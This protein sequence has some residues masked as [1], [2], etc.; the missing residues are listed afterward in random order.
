VA[1]PRVRLADTVSD[2]IAASI[3]S[4]Q[5]PPGARLPSERDL[6][7]RHQVSRAAIREA[8]AALASRGLVRTR[9]GYRP[10]VETLN[11]QTAID[12]VGRLVAH[13]LDAPAGVLNLFDTRIFLE[14]ALARHAARHA[15]PAD[16]AALREALAANRDAVGDERFYRTDVAFHGVLYRI[17]GN[18]IY[19]A[20][21][22]A[23]VDWLTAH[24]AR[25]PRGA[26]IDRVALAGHEAIFAAILER[27]GDRAEQMLR[28]H[29]AM[30]WELV[31][32]TFAAPVA[33]PGDPDQAGTER[34]SADA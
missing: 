21:H 31:R 12:G 25:M 9:R 1:T 5:L 10:L 20:V 23:Y 7:R 15:A 4:G 30:A 33:G 22:R 11:A 17:P 28:S 6:M 13:L 29:L 32:S 3:R 2:A 19:P 26:Q 27:D 16:I 14:A 34:A 8:I 18:P 24:W